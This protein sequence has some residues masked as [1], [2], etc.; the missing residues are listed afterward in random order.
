MENEGAQSGDGATGG[1][2]SKD[3]SGKFVPPS[4]GSWIPKVRHDEAVNAERGRVARLEA[5]LAALRLAQQR[6]PEKDE[7]PAKRYT[8]AELN[9]AVSSQT[10]T[11]DQADEIWAK[12]IREDAKREV[13][14]E[15][16][17]IVEANLAQERVGTDLEEYKRLAP[18][19]MEDGSETRQRVREE[20]DYLV[21]MGHAGKVEDPKTLQTQLLAIRAVL[22]PIDKLRTAKSARRDT[23]SHEETGGASAGG[24]RRQ[25]KSAWDSLD[26]RQKDYYEAKIRDGM[27][28]DKA[29]VEAELK[30]SRKPH[31]GRTSARA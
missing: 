31:S 11:A 26:K 16:L 22:G 25:A 28:K 13:K 14:A 24:Q 5:E 30:F 6:Q 21:S 2:Q 8:K 19:I 4:D 10:I 23:E 27:Y 1:D 17:G 18:E 9:A 12:Q 15:V 20:F 7:E 3:G 29:A